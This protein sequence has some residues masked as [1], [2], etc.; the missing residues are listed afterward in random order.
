MLCLMLQN[1][2]YSHG[3]KTAGVHNVLEVE[4]QYEYVTVYFI[5]IPLLQ[6]DVNNKLSYQ[7]CKTSNKCPRRLL[8]HVPQNPGF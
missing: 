5:S 3:L 8:E 6:H 7:Y 1:S 2:L 4:T